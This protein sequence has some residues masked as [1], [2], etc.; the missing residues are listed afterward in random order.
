M[1]RCVSVCDLIFTQL[2]KKPHISYTV[3]QFNNKTINVFRC[4]PIHLLILN[5][6]LGRTNISLLEILV[7][8]T[9]LDGSSR[10]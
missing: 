6:G 2:T 4:F 10:I 1:D 9:E 7:E 3:E 5:T 8:A